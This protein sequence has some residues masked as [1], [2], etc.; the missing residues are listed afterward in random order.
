MTK[1]THFNSQKF[2]NDLIKAMNLG[3]ENP[4]KVEKLRKDIEIQIAEIIISSASMTL[5]PNLA[6]AII[7]ENSEIKDPLLIYQLMIEAS[8][9]TQIAILEALEEFKINIITVYSKLKS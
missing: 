6:E 8:P 5:D 2:I 1:K 9:Q 4:E 7:S 3:H